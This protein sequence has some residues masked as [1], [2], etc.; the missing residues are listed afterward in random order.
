MYGVVSN[1]ILFQP[2]NNDELA[3]HL[4]ILLSNA[5]LRSRM[6]SESLE[7]IA[8]HGRSEVLNQWE[9]LY[10]SLSARFRETN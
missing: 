6:G 10:Q 5:N 8:K 3:Y 1:G 2:G 4:D 9:A 7:L